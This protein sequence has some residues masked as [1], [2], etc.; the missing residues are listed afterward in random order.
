MLTNSLRLACD[1]G[2]KPF[3]EAVR[4]PLKDQ[5]KEL[6]DEQ[7]QCGLKLLEKPTNP[8]SAPSERSRL[9]IGKYRRK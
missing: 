9:R 5:V 3:N 6:N 1:V 4:Q 2:W 7:K 8:E